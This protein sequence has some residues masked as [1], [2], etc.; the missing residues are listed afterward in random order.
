MR[1]AFEAWAKGQGYARLSTYGITARY[2]ASPDDYIEPF[3]QIAWEAWQAATAAE[4]EQCARVC[5]ATIAPWKQYR[6]GTT[7][8]EDAVIACAAAIRNRKEPA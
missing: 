4:R 5:E 2:G 1:Q 7:E 3:L 6:H 8:V